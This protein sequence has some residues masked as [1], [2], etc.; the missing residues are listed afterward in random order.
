[1]ENP[2]DQ[3]YWEAEELRRFGFRSVGNNVRVAKNCTIIGL[4]NIT[5]GDNVRI[6]GRSSL[7]CAAGSLTIGSY[8]HIGSG[9]YLAC[10]GG[11]ELQD[12]SGLS[13]NVSIY[14]TSDDYSGSSLTNPTIPLEYLNPITK[15]VSIL[16][17][18]I[19]G[20]G[21]VILPGI[22]LGEGSAVGALSLVNRDLDAWSIYSGTPARRLKSRKKELLKFE[23][24]LLTGE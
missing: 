14:S 21:S 5:I 10:S 23:K 13:Q 11:I 12:F 2:F 7:A 15:K 3:G 8:I 16:R 4:E 20:S 18:V 9:C 1:M 24:A 19:V 6:D 22:T 17:H